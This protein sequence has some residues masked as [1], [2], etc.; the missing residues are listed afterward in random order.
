MGLSKNSIES[1]DTIFMIRSQKIVKAV[2]PYSFNHRPNF[3]HQPYDAWMT[4]GG[5]TA[6]S[7]YPPKFL[8]G[9]VYK[10][11]LMSFGQNRKETRLRFVE[12]VSMSFDTFPDY[13]RYEIIPMIWDCWPMYFNQ[14]VGWLRKYHVR[15]VI[16]TSS[17]TAERMRKEFPGMN[18]LAVT[19]GINTQFYHA[20][21]A[22][23]DRSIDLLE[24]GSMERNFFP[25]LV[26]GI[27]HVNRNNADGCMDSFEQLTDTMSH[28]KVTIALPRCDT[29]PELT[30][31]IE[32]LTLR[33]WECMLSR[34]VLLGRAPKELIDLIGYNPVIDLDKNN[35]DQQVRE[36][37]SHISDYQELVDKNR[38]TALRMAPWEIRMKTVMGWIVGLGYEI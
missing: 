13:M 28:A 21:E 29:A 22:L 3:K 5:K 10:Y 15:T 25:E 33:F 17:Q 12:P 11:S 24:Y 9:L 30:G 37:V 20:G 27:N 7:H 18:I 14:V 6:D 38:E 35:P 34:T 26:P 1:L 4:M 16:F 19:E 8:H 2:E 36:I 31:D 32:T 23:V